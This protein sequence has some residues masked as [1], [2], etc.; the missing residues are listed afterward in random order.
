MSVDGGLLAQ[1]IVYAGMDAQRAAV[2]LDL[3]AYLH[4]TGE[5]GPQLFLGTPDLSTIDPTEAFTLF[6]ALRDAMER[7]QTDDQSAVLGGYHAIAIATA[8]QSSRG[9]HVMGRRDAPLDDGEREVLA[10]I[11][12]A[13]GAVVHTLE[14]APRSERNAGSTNAPVRVAVE[15][16][17]GR[18]RA[19]V[20]VSVGEEIRT[21]VAD[22]PTPAKA[23]ALAVL[24]AVDAGIKLVDTDDGDIGGMRAVLALIVDGLGRQE[25]G[26]AVITADRD[27]LA[28]TA[29]A[30]LDA[31]AKLSASQP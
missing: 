1:D 13:F 19:E 15:M 30:T 21:G 27:V 18:A 22:G 4:A 8:G 5:Q 10:K 7:P 25:V 24:D 14:D 6:G 12:R 29:S 16:V 26:S 20:S 3:C 2:A 31:C 23:V 28:A 11:A 17:S 9:L